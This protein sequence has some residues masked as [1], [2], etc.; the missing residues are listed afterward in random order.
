MFCPETPR[1]L[2]KKDNWEAAEKV[3]VRLRNLPADHPYIRNEL[4]DIR[5]QAEYLN[6]GHLSPKQMFKRLFQAGTRNR[7]GI[8][9]LLMCCQNMTGMNTLL[10]DVRSGLMKKRCEHH[11]ILFSS[12]LRDTRNHWN[13]HQTLCDRFLRSCQNLGNDRFLALAS[14]ESRSTQR[15]NL[16]CLYRIAPHVVHRRIRLQ[17]RPCHRC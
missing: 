10:E 12:Y 1:F 4:A 6:A 7:I 2:A 9:L 15:S 5:Q 17:G 16:W 14:R 8:G 13:R 3:L 11:Y